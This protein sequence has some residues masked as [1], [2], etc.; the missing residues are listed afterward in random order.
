[1]NHALPP[2]RDVPPHRQARIR[3]RL[4]Q[5]VT[6]R[7]AR[8]A[9]LVTA[10]VATAAVVAL[11]AVLAPWQ[12]DGAD[13]A[14]ASGTPVELS[15]TAAGPSTTASPATTQPEIPGLSPERIAEIAEGCAASAGVDGEAVLHQ[16]VTD[17]VGTLALLYTGHHMLSCTVDGPTMPYNSAMTGGFDVGWLPGEF[18]ADQVGSSSGGDG[19]KPEHAGSLGYDLAVGR[20]TDRVAKVV[21]RNGGKS[22]QAHLANGT[23]VARL[24]HPSDWR[25]PEGWDQQ[26][27]LQAYDAQ[28]ALLGDWFRDW[29]R[30]RCWVRPDGVVVRGARDVDPATCAPAVAWR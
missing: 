17:E 11:V 19:G 9:P 30:T 5:E 28:G 2:D 24:P 27:V 4:E 15:T 10:G 29:D 16:Y 3:A 12:P 8:F 22:V 21:Y 14:A 7:A 18:V 26:A 23:F 6:R 25:V 13:P 1:M 20:V